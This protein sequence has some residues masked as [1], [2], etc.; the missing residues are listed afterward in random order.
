LKRE[1]RRLIDRLETSAEDFLT[2]LSKLPTEDIHHAPDSDAWTLHQVAAH[3]RDVE[4][5]V[6]LYR[7]KRM[8]NE[9]NPPVENFDQKAWTREH[10]NG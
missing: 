6:F 5:E 2:Y 3:V 4:Q 9:E 1:H 8:L 10:Y 7:L